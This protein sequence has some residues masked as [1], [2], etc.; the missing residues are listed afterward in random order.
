MPLQ[1]VGVVREAPALYVE[2]ACRACG[3][4]LSDEQQT[5]YGRLFSHWAAEE[6]DCAHA[7]L[8]GRRGTVHVTPELLGA[9]AG[10][11]GGTVFTGRTCSAFAAGVM[12]L[13]LARGEIEN[14]RLRVLRMIGMMSMGGD[15]FADKFNAFNKSMNSATACR[16]GLRSSTATYNAARS[17]A[18][19]SPRLRVSGATSTTTARGGVMRLLKVSRAECT[20]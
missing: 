17:R 9:T 14:S 13:G 3:S 12:A 4:S 19:I 15:A 16:S 5:A 11:M 18:A 10:L 8:R 2:T 7:V 6:F 1:C 20:A